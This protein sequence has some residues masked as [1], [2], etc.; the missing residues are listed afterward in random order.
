MTTLVAGWR[1]RVIRTRGL[2]FH[3]VE[4]GVVDGPVLLL[5]HGFPEFWYAWR[6]FIDALVALGYR[7]V[8]PDQRGYNLSDRP[9]GARKYVGAHIAGDCIDLLDALGAERATLVGHDWGGH[10]AWLVAE[11]YP[12]R[13]RQL[14]VLNAAHPAVMIRN[15]FTNPR[16]LL[17]SWYGIFLQL[18]FIPELV[19]R[20]RNF[21]LLRRSLRLADGSTMD[22]AETSHYIAAWS[23]PGALTGMINWYRGLLR[24]ISFRPL[25]RI[26][27][28]MLLLWGERDQFLTPVLAGES[29]A[30]CDRG[31]VVTLPLGTHWLHHDA[32]DEVIRRI[33][34]FLRPVDAALDT[35]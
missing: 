31:E 25:P 22:A 11:W 15:V 18:P 26:T 10:V 24:D 20:A 16:Q 35:V 12:E 27:V 33:S 29:I 2:S 13:V 34:A 4:A 17:K 3:I 30:L 19:L 1:E 7:V 9:R 5:L 23:R 8:V 21:A 28:Q 32:T 6:G 14:V